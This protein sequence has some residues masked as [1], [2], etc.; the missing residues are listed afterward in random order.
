MRNLLLNIYTTILR[1]GEDPKVID[2]QSVYV[3]CD[4]FFFFSF[5]AYLSW[6][7]KWV[8]LIVCR[9]SDR[10]SVCLWTVHIYLLHQT[11]R[12]ICTKLLGKGNSDLFNWRATPLFKGR[13]WPKSENTWTKFKWK[14][15]I[16]RTTGTIS[17][18]LATK[19]KG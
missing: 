6:Q 3:R 12:P 18:K 14:I 19:D 16:S 4:F 7:L 17:T 15:F 5:L 8:F 2:V 11:T 10:L 1:F 13:Y 9:L